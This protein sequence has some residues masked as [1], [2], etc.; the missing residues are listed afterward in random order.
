M[1]AILVQLYP[2]LGLR[3][4]SVQPW[5]LIY[6]KFGRKILDEAPLKH[7]GIQMKFHEGYSGLILS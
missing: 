7:S 4:K 5:V 6:D 2:K 1:K 3:D